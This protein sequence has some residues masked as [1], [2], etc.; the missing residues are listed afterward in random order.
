[1][2]L[3]WNSTWVNSFESTWSII[4]KI[5][6]ANA[7]SSREF[8]REFGSKNSSGK[9]IKQRSGLL[10]A[11]GINLDYLAQCSGTDFHKHTED[12]FNKIIGMFTNENTSAYLRNEFTYCENC[13]SMG[14]HSL[15]HQFIFVHRCPF[16][17]S[18][19][20]NKCKNCGIIASCDIHNHSS[21]GGFQCSCSNYYS[22][23]KFH[24][25]AGWQIQ[26]KFKDKGILNWVT[27]DQSTY[28]RIKES[29]FYLPS[30]INMNDPLQFLLEFGRRA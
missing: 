10:K 15:L 17:L 13:L 6:Y 24:S 26:L 23:P 19:L 27:M 28:N 8:I 2:R 21:K 22:D 5:K 14:Y 16:H 20:K 25:F 12:Y 4:E 11:N 30:L 3:T 9:L 29:Y 7:I 18:D 1:M